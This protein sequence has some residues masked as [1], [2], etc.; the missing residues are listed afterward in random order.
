VLKDQN[1]HSTYIEKLHIYALIISKVLAFWA[2]QLSEMIQ[3]DSDNKVH[4]TLSIFNRYGR[5][6]GSSK[7]NWLIEKEYRSA[8]VHILINYIEVK[9]ILQ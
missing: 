7:D 5:P 3:W 9:S 4:Y 2:I 6:S 8:H 1:V